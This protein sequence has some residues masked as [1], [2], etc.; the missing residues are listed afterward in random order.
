MWE[1]Q[2]LQ[3]KQG[4]FTRRDTEVVAVVVDPVEQNAQVVRDLGLGYR[5]VADP[6]L[7]MIDAYGLRHDQG[8]DEPPI[9]RPATFLIDADGVVR[10]RDLTDNYRLRP[11]PEAILVA[12]DEIG[13]APQ[14]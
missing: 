3:L 11:R 2:G 10:W 5:I 7:T 1:L 14:K 13:G 9:A 12:I 6:S 4:E 8:P